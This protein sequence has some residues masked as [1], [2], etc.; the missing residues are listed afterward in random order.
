[1]GNILPAN[2]G[3]TRDV[4]LIP[5]SGRSPRVENG[6]LF[7]NSCLENS[8]GRGAWWATVDGVAK[9]WIRLSA[10]TH[11]N[12]SNLVIGSSHVK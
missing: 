8:M 2:P 7:H 1:M 10:H 4:C 3:D 12:T 5:G 6:N 11:A 9:G